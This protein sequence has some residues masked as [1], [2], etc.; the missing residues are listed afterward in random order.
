MSEKVNHPS[1]YCTENYE[2]IEV[3]KEVFGIEAVK[4]A[5]ICNAF[6]YL[7]RHQKKSGK[8][9]IEKA[10]CCLNK[11]LELMGEDEE[12]P[13]IPNTEKLDN[14][15]SGTVIQKDF[16]TGEE[17]EFSVGDVVKHFKYETLDEELKER[18]CYT[19][20]IKGFATHTE[21]K[22]LLV[23]Y[24]ALYGDNEVY[25][26]PMDMFFSE[27]DREKYPNIKQKYRFEKI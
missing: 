18:Q 6:E 14:G 4:A 20:K 7:W 15:F 11:Y 21:T 10:A 23:I 1:H 13:I 5:Y 17:R 12:K 2:C 24:Q 8:E 26:R 3:E 27:V 19:Y 9:D 16:K 22:E 25:A